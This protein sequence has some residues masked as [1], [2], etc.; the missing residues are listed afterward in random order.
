MNKRDVELMTAEEVAKRLHI[1]PDTVR[2]WSRRG[3]IP[4]I[5]LSPKV[6]RYD[7][8]AVIEAMRIRHEEGGDHV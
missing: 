4:R 7:F 1:R 8:A 6:V 2:T 5:Q 3:L